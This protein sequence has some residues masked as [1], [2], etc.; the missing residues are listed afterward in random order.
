MNLVHFGESPIHGAGVFS[1][2]NFSPRDFILK[3]DH[4]R[5]VSDADPLEPVRWEFEHQWD[6]LADGKV[7]LMQPPERLINLRCDPN[8]FTRTI[9]ADRYVVALRGIRPGE[10]IAYD[11]WSGTAPAHFSPGPS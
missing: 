9:A 1:S 2:A 5:V 11:Y 10:E 6:Y 7:V 3:I 4:S 8:T